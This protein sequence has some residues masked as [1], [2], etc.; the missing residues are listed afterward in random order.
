MIKSLLTALITCALLSASSSAQDPGAME[1]F[2]PKQHRLMMP[3]HAK[4]LEEQKKQDA[5]LEPLLA[6]VNSKS[7]EK[8][9]D[10]MAAVLRKLIEQ[11]KTTIQ[12]IAGH[13]DR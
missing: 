11:R 1:K 4:I 3:V 9:M 10:A 12:M 2:S 8:R 7:G 5:A 13:L 6:A